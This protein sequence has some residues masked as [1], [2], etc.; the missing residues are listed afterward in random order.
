MSEPMRVLHLIDSLRYGGA[1][2]LLFELTSR[3]DAYGFRPSVFYCEPGP[4]VDEFKRKKIPVTRLAWL[5]RVDPLLLAG[6]V[7]AIR[8]EHP[9]IVHT[10]LF[11]S[12]FHGRL[13]ARMAGVPVVVSTLHNCNAWAKN[14]LFGWTYGFTA[15]FADKFIAVADEVRDYDIRYLHIPPQKILTI[16]NAVSV[17]R[18]EGQSDKGLA[19]R[20]EFNISADAPLLGMIGRLE[21]QK[22]HENFLRAAARIH[23]DHPAAR[24]FI[25]GD[26][27]LRGQLVALTHTLGLQDAVTFCGLRKDI[28]AVMAALDMLVISSQYEGLPVVLLEAMAAG[29]PIVSTAVSGVI[30]VVADGETGILVPPSNSDALA[31]ACL[32]LI[33]N[34]EL[35]RKMGQNGYARVKSR[36]GMTAMTEKTVALYRDLISTHGVAA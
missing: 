28:P 7:N 17:E 34:P 12:D 5:A 24:F 20:K 32:R 10:H 11:K 3:L 36:Y 8:K 19:V 1:E 6:M 35:R 33:G 16:P 13:A 26:G 29:L 22:D 30:S 14:P 21:P 23:T 4:L 2:T 9:Q 31:D 27:S 18:F 15:K 25:V